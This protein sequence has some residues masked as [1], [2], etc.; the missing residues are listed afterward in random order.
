MFQT[1][2]LTIRRKTTGLQEPSQQEPGQLQKLDELQELAKLQE[3]GKPRLFPLC[4]PNLEVKSALVSR[5]L[6]SARPFQDSFSLYTLG[7]ALLEG[8]RNKNEK[9]V[10]TSFHGFLSK[11]PHNVLLPFEASYQGWLLLALGFADQSVIAEEVLADGRL[12]VHF[13]T[14]DGEDFIV[15]LKFIPEKKKK[16]KKKTAQMT[17]EEKAA[18]TARIENDMADMIKAA[19]SQIE[20]KN[21]IS[22]FQGTGQKIWKVAM[23]VSY[24]T[25]VRV[26][27]REA[28]NWRLVKDESA[29]YKIEFSP[30]Q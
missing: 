4:L 8:F 18:E 28:A 12:D 17:P 27:I 29:N 23:V 2:Y 13:V 25:D 16:K 20:N 24:R 7:K 19:M 10:E 26:V 5:L 21:Y 3:L 22:K 6:S 15:E 9:E 30:G 14:K 11:L 1:G